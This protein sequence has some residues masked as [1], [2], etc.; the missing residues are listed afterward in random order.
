MGMIG[1]MEANMSKNELTLSDS[2]CVG[3]MRD[4]TR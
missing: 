3:M 2:V 1:G 4:G